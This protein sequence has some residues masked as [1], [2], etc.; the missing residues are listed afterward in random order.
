M[1]PL[2]LFAACCLLAPSSPARA[3]FT[4]AWVGTICPGG[5]DRSAGQCANF[6]LELIERD[7]KVCGAHMYATP[8]AERIDEGAAPSVTADLADGVATGIAVSG[9]G[10]TPVRIPVAL[11]IENGTLRWQRLESPP[12][13]YL[14][15]RNARLT[16]SK[17]RTLFAP[18]FEQELRAACTYVF[19]L[20]A[21]QRQAASPAASG[22]SAPT[23]V[24]AASPVPAR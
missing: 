1:R 21:Q 17:S 14:L 3:D 8:G 13:D 9:L 4:G 16:R 23:P 18:L 20:A 12:G 5:A 22:G 15:P 7:G 24:P 10:P 19:N 6:V 11:Q 2:A